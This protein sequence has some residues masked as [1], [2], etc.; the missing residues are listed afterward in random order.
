MK[1]PISPWLWRI[2]VNQFICIF[3]HWSASA[4]CS[5]CGGWSLE[6]VAYLQ[7]TSIFAVDEFKALTATVFH[8][9]PQLLHGQAKLHPDVPLHG[10]CH[11]TSRLQLT[12]LHTH[13]QQIQ[14]SEKPQSK[15]LMW[16]LLNAPVTES[17]EQSAVLCYLPAQP[18][19]CPFPEHV[20]NANQSNNEG[21]SLLSQGLFTFWEV[22]SLMLTVTNKVCLLH[23][24]QDSLSA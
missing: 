18:P 4:A 13:K 7:N 24:D 22:V 23:V 20:Q 12:T 14:V 1:S 3:L 21:R 8:Q 6:L 15:N 2:S 17:S 16:H 9:L 11:S 5:T 19:S 10:C